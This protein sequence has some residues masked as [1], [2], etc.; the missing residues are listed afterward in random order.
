MYKFAHVSEMG[1]KALGLS[2]YVLHT[3]SGASISSYLW[4]LRT[5]EK[6]LYPVLKLQKDGGKMLLLFGR[7]CIL[8][9]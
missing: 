4:Q 6:K 8:T 7:L 2:L 5:G 3:N 9:L 1:L